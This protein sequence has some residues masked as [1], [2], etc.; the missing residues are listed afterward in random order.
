MRSVL[1]VFVGVVFW[2]MLWVGG[3]GV[4]RT[5]MPGAFDGSGATQQSGVLAG[6]LLYSVLLS[7]GAGY[8]TAW[9]VNRAEVGHALVLGVIQLG[10]GVAVQLQFWDVMP[11]WYHVLFLAM[12]IPGGVY[13]GKRRRDRMFRSAPVLV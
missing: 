6:M 3:N 2:G 5:A 4:L 9:V 7:V 10:I 1:A 11:L 13:G 8:V 12:L